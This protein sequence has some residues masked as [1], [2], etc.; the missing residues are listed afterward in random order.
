MSPHNVAPLIYP[1]IL[2]DA[3]GRSKRAPEALFSSLKI[4]VIGAADGSRLSEYTLLPLTAPL[5]CSDNC[6]KQHSASA[7]DEYCFH[8]A[9]GVVYGH[10]T[11]C[12][13]ETP[14][15]VAH[16]YRVRIAGNDV[17]HYVRAGRPY[18]M[19]HGGNVVAGRHAKTPRVKGGTPSPATRDQPL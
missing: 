10:Q 15:D 4:A 1:V 11:P 6:A 5:V 2:G 12:S 16:E 13:Q 14:T 17:F 3:M 9:T 7:S 8:A 19:A 18:C